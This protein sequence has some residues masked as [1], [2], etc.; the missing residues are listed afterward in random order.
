MSGLIFAD[1]TVLMNDADGVGDR[2][3]RTPLHYAALTGDVEKVRSQ[4]DSGADIDCADKQGFTALH[5]AAQAQRLD[6]LLVLLEGGANIGARDKWGN[7]ALVK[8]VFNSRGEGGCIRALLSSGADPDVAN[9][10]GVSPRLLADR[11][12]N[13]DV[14]QFFT[15]I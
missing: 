1:D 8:A 3:G 11:I 2:A 7:T 15:D 12:G 10:S 13:F 9:D 4:L 14:A 5:F 6:A